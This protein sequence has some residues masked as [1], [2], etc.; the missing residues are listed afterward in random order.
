[1]DD[2]CITYLNILIMSWPRL[3]SKPIIPFNFIYLKLQELNNLLSLQL[4]DDKCH[5][6]VKHAKNNLLYGLCKELLIIS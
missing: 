4:N 6:V 2:V 5:C 3:V 1:M